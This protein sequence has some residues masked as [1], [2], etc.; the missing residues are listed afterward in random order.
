MSKQGEWKTKRS[1]KET[2]VQRTS[3]TAK[4]FSSTTEYAGQYISAVC[5]Y[6]TAATYL[7]P[8]QIL[9]GFRYLGKENLSL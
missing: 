5:Q 6:S 7:T 9:L 8:K 4:R 1:V 2:S 3:P